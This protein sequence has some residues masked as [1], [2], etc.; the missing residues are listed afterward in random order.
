M[1]PLHPLA[2]IAL[3]MTLLTAPLAGAATDAAT[4]PVAATTDFFAKISAKDLD[5]VARY[6]PADGFTETVPESKD[7]LHLDAK[8]FDGL[9]KSGK[10]ID[11]RVADLALQRFGDSAL[12]TGTRLGGIGAPNATPASGRLAFTMLWTRAPSGWQLRHLH[13]SPQP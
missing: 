5:A 7:L 12:V 1:K 2:S 8:A 6:L 4:D 13:L 11:L 9:F 3:A 10:Q